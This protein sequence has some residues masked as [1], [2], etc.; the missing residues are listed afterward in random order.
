MTRNKWLLI[1]ISVLS[2]Y[3]VW[4][5]ASAMR[6]EAPREEKIT[7]PAEGFYAPD[8]TLTTL[9]GDSF[10]LSEH[11]GQPI[12]LTLWA[13]WCTPCKAE[14]PDF[15]S[16]YE[17]MSDDVL[18]VGVN[19]TNQDNI[20]DVRDFVD[21][22]HLIFPI[23]LD[24][25]GQVSRLYQLQGLPQTFF[26]DENGIIQARIVGGPIPA[27]SVRTSFEQL[28]AEGENVSGN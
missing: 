26:I 21:D 27:A 10:T 17:E 11:Y 8:F 9:E 7:S 3:I 23:V 1:S 16:V 15:N 12:L 24:E 20:N 13:S 28:L 19:V 6:Y 18:V 4:I 5:L 25:K 2:I 22:N 14:M